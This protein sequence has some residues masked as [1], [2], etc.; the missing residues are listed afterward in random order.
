MNCRVTCFGGP[1]SLGARPTAATKAS[2]AV[3]G[4]THSRFRNAFIAR[5]SDKEEEESYEYGKCGFR[6]IPGIFIE[7]ILNN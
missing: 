3:Q 6:N 7:N 2:I 1:K 5:A 4:H